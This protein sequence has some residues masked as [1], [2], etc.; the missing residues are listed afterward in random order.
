[1]AQ[2]HVT[3]FGAQGSGAQV[4]VVPLPVFVTTQISP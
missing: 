2:E 4:Q 1:M 3:M